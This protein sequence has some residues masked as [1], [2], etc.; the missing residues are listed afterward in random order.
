MSS[1]IYD[2][3]KSILYNFDSISNELNLA[4][5]IAIHV[6]TE[7]NIKAFKEDLKQISHILGSI[8]SNIKNTGEDITTILQLT[9]E[10]T[11]SLKR[12]EQNIEI[13]NLLKQL[14]QNKF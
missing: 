2:Q 10:N 12:L 13:A 4:I 9:I 7:N 5:C 3:L 6:Q 11:K 8:N 14:E 1:S